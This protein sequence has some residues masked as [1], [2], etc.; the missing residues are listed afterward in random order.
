[1]AAPGPIPLRQHPGVVS[2][3]TALATHC[4]ATDCLFTW[5]FLFL[6]FLCDRIS[7]AA[8]DLQRWDCRHR[9]PQHDW[10]QAPTVS[11][12]AFVPLGAA[13]FVISL[14]S[15]RFPC[16]LSALSTS[17]IPISFCWL[18]YSNP[19]PF[20]SNPQDRFLDSWPLPTRQAKDTDLAV[21]VKIPTWDGHMFVFLS[22][23]YLTQPDSF[24]FHPVSHLFHLSL[25]QNKIPLHICTTSP[26]STYPFWILSQKLEGK[27][28]R[29]S[30][31][32]QTEWSTAWKC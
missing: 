24:R 25:W 3:L 18:V 4:T 14:W 2:F 22:P 28:L 21:R 23:D 16:D 9:P 27:Q 32:H 26:L 8:L 31:D 20:F 10:T 15:H 13:S 29:E 11:Q 17:V 30:L 12:D 6:S 1:M 7:Y 19:S 5:R